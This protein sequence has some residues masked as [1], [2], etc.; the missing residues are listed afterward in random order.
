MALEFLRR[1][2]GRAKI[3]AVCVSRRS[4]HDAMRTERLFTGARAPLERSEPS[5]MRGQCQTIGRKRKM[6]GIR[7]FSGANTGNL[8]VPQTKTSTIVFNDPW[9]VKGD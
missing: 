3:S 5:R 9:N 2:P 6:I 7:L 4:S 8:G 1:N